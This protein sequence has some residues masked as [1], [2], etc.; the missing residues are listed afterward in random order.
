MMSQA[1]KQEL[2][3]RFL[4]EPDLHSPSVHVLDTDTGRRTKVPL[5]AYREVRRVLNELFSPGYDQARVMADYLS[6][7]G[8]PARIDRDG[9]A[10]VARPHPVT[11]GVYGLSLEVDGVPTPDMGHAWVFSA[12]PLEEDK[13]ASPM[14][15]YKITYLDGRYDSMTFEAWDAAFP[16]IYRVYGR[17]EEAVERVEAEELPAIR[18][19]SGP[20]R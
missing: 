2:P 6:K 13:V 14:S 4:A 3:E 18:R 10:F 7:R 12:Q 5:F 17:L 16:E 1:D 20:R 11:P 15:G 9:H 8:M 19:S